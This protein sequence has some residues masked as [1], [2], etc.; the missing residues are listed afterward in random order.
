[1]QSSVT[2]SSQPRNSLRPA[3]VK[4]LPP[5]K[6]PRLLDQV[7]ERVRMMHYGLRTEQAYVRV[8]D[9]EFTQSAIYVR[10]GKGSKDR[11]VMLPASLAPGLQGTT[12]GEPV[13]LVPGCRSR[14]NRRRDARRAGTEV[15]AGANLA[16]RIL[17]RQIR[18]AVSGSSSSLRRDLPASLQEGGGLCRHCEAGH[19]AHTAAL[20][21]DASAPEG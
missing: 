1:M 17:I 18:A 2:R 20:L 9:I 10:Q 7:R 12:G 13:G 19:A 14:T 8:K 4:E 3:A 16:R 5:L 6:A 11:V 15:S 21:R